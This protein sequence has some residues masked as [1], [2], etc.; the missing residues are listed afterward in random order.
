MEKLKHMKDCLMSCVQSQV[1]GNLHNVDAKELGEAIDMIKDLSEAIY[2]CTITKSM[3]ETDK[4]R[5]YTPMRDMDK[6]YGTMY[7]TDSHGVYHPSANMT[8][9]N[10]NTRNYPTGT[11]LLGS[12]MNQ[13]DGKEDRGIYWFSRLLEHFGCKLCIGGH[14]HTY[15]LS[16]PIKENYQWKRDSDSKYQDSCYIDNGNY[17]SNPK[18]MSSTLEDESGFEPDY[19]ITWEVKTNKS[20]NG[21]DPYNVKTSKLISISS[22]KTP[23]IPSN[24]YNKIGEQKFINGNVDYYRCCTPIDIKQ[25]TKYDGF[26]NYSMCQATG[27][28]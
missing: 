8:T 6:R 19:E 14:K 17:I 2:Y 24:L 7:F 1:S 18:P 16:Y 26:V 15:S 23:Y 28:K 27:Y 25:N 22:T 20:D 4:E 3:E 21:D 11:S 13:L 10:P 9:V 12:H 5:Y